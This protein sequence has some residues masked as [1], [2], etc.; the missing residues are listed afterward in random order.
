MNVSDNEKEAGKMSKEGLDTLQKNNQDVKTQSSS[1]N[2]EVKKAAAPAGEAPKK[3]IAAVYRPQNSQQRPQR[4]AANNANRDGKAQGQNGMPKAATFKSAEGEGKNQSAAP[5]NRENRPQSQGKRDGVR[6]G[7]SGTGRD[8]RDGRVQG[9]GSTGRDNRDGRV[10]GQGSTSR[11]NRDGV[12]Q[13]QNGTGR[14]NR[15]RRPG[16]NG[17]NR[18][19]RDGRVQGQGSTGRDSRQ[20]QGGFNRDGRVQG[21]SGAGRDNRDGRPGQNGFNRDNRDGRPQGQN[22]FNRDGGRQ[23]GTGRDGARDGRSQ[24]GTGRDGGN[25]DNRGSAKRESSSKNY[26]T[27]IQTKPQSNRKSNNNNYK[28]DKF[29][30]NTKMVEDGPRTKGGKVSKHPFIMPQKQT[31]EKIE[32]T[33][34]MIT[35]PEV[36]T[37]KDLAEA[38]KLQPSVLIKKLFMQGQ[39]MTLNSEIDFEKAEEIAMEYDV[40][41]EKEEKVDV[42][43]EL[44][45]E[46]EENED[47]MV[48]RPPVVCVMGHVDHGK[49][50]LLDAIR[51]TNVTSRE[52][53]GITQ[54]IGAYTVEINGQQITFL[55]TPG[56]EAFTAMR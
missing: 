56:H 13:G 2:E 7:Q 14:D 24:G 21:Q 19:N 9:Q 36:L 31:V 16:Q 51:S 35:I 22:S 32:E 11:D 42:I 6:Q 23:G 28:N 50:S 18:D 55:D 20:S 33:V 1:I 40:L 10:Q 12:R 17:F 53:G 34:K 4:P 52:A 29:E 41:C 26:D 30:K 49:T 48:S 43:A 3:K 37:I 44:L 27:P 54:H 47:D 39:I 46:D 15:E 45:K 5:A 25:R 8:N 38:M